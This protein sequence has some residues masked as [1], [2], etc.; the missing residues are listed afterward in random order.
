MSVDHKNR[1]RTWVS[2]TRYKQGPSRTL[3][4]TEPG[5]TDEPSELVIQCWAD[6]RHTC[7][8]KGA[9]TINEKCKNSTVDFL[10]IGWHA[11]CP[12]RRSVR[13]TQSLKDYSFLPGG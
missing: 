4:S 1:D 10:S 2:G 6:Q 13:T 5:T 9:S 3:G 7:P 11:I 8:L 12:I